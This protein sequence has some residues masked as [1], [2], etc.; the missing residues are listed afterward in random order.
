MTEHRAPAISGRTRAHR[1]TIP[2]AV[3]GSGTGS[4][5]PSSA[6]PPRTSRPGCGKKYV[7]RADPASAAVNHSSIPGFSTRTS[8]PR[9]GRSPWSGPSSRAASPA[10]FTPTGAAAAG[11]P[12][13]AGDSR[14]QAPASS[15]GSIR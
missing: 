7:V 4:S 10:Q 8:C 2:A 1:A 6:V 11:S 12:Y 9:T 5:A 13:T 3:A 14:A 15:A